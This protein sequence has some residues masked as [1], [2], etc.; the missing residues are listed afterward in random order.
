MYSRYLMC[1]LIHIPCFFNHSIIHSF[2]HSFFHL[3]IH[4]HFHLFTYLF[5]CLTHLFIHIHTLQEN[6]SRMLNVRRSWMMCN[7]AIVRGKSQA[8]RQWPTIG[9]SCTFVVPALS[10]CPSVLLSVYLSVCLSFVFPCPCNESA[11]WSSSRVK[12]NR[13][14]ISRRR[15]LLR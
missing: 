13:F 8:N 9:L 14:L 6:R 15:L 4:S 3:F 7:A 10:V 11:L 1:S 2:N 5:A 12:F